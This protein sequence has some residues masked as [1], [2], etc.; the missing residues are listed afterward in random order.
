MENQDKKR[1]LIIDAALKRFAH[2][3]LAKTT[4]TEI[5]KDISFSK[6]LLYYYF[7]DKL[8][9]YVSVIEN[10]MHTLSR[11]LIKSV[12][13]TSTAKEGIL[14]L[15]QKRQAFI[16]KYYKLIEYTQMIGP[17]LPEALYEKFTRARA[18]ELKIITELLN[19]GNASG[20]FF[21]EDVAFTT[22]I[23]VEA[24]SGIHFNILTRAKNLFPGKDEFK[25]IF[26]KEKRFAEIF[27]A[28]L[29]P[30]K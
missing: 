15:L 13:K 22:E 29:K 28:G 3:G 30:V 10:M 26:L 1:L 8:S 11:D 19:K 23:F 4:M 25:L 2:Y 21:V 24:V 14:M 17:E 6:A 7:P 9:L 16:Q 18:F 27:V 5:A 12:E 20:E